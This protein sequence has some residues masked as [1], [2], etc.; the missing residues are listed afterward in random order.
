[1]FARLRE[2]LLRPS[3]QRLPSRP[4]ADS[5]PV[6]ICWTAPCRATA[7]VV[8]EPVGA[9][10][11]LLN[12]EHGWA[13]RLN[14]TGKRVWEMANQGR[15]PEQI[16]A[17][18]TTAYGLDRERARGDVAAV[19]NQLLRDRLIAPWRESNDDTTRA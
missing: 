5:K 10:L 3:D 18:F 6:P 14:A 9:S 8:A 17:D 19:L 2:L 7:G 11:V 1:M 13:F 12:L 15:T 4:S 16:A